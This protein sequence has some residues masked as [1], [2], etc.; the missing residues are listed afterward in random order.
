MT[1]LDTTPPPVASAGRQRETASARYR[2]TLRARGVIY[3]KAA[4]CE[5][6]TLSSA[7]AAATYAQADLR[8]RQFVGFAAECLQRKAEVPAVALV[9]VRAFAQAEVEADSITHGAAVRRL[10]HLQLRFEI[11]G[12]ASR[13]ALDGLIRL[14]QPAIASQAA[15]CCTGVSVGYEHLLPLDTDM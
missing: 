8:L 11:E 5:V 12:E 14:A 1:T 9:R 10:G 15:S 3:H 7:D 6:E 2:T 13:E 4:S